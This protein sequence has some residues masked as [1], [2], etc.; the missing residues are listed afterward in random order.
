[1][2]RGRGLGAVTPSDT[3]PPIALADL[4]KRLALCAR[5]GVTCYRDGMLSIDLTSN[6]KPKEVDPEFKPVPEM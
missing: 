2:E 6:K 1:M 3:R 4:E 5:Y